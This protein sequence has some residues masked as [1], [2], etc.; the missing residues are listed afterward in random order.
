[1]VKDHDYWVYMMSNKT[2]STLY[3]G[4][5]GDLLVRV[6]QHRRGEI[7]GFTPIITVRNLV[8]CSHFRDIRDAIA[9]E[10]QLKVG[11]VRKRM[12][13]WSATTHAGKTWPQIGFKHFKQNSQVL[14]LRFALRNSAQDDRIR[15]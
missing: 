4:V 13:L 10:K 14:R 7:P 9:W 1:M 6:A 11:G 2:R 15:I 5:T 8:Y 3:I 12:R